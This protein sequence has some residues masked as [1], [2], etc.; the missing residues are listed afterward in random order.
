MGIEPTYNPLQK[1][2]VDHSA[3]APNFTPK[4]PHGDAVS[5]RHP[6]CQEG[7][8]LFIEMLCGT[9]DEQRVTRTF[10]S[11]QYSCFDVHPSTAGEIR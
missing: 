6:S 3:T 5:N 11:G 10:V 2:G 8:M 1:E 4:I 9:A 7:T